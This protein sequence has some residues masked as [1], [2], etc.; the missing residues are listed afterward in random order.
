M[1][2][3]E[4]RWDYGQDYSGLRYEP[5]EGFCKHSHESSGSIKGW[6]ILE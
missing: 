1:H 6:E 4:I 2:L 5:M 3:G